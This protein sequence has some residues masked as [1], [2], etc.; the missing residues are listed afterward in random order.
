MGLEH[1]YK[2]V[3]LLFLAHLIEHRRAVERLIEERRAEFI[4]SK[5]AEIA[6]RRE[7]EEREAERRAVVEQ[8]RQRLLREHAT[9]LLGY[10]PKV[11]IGQGWGKI[12]FVQPKIQACSWFGRGSGV[13]QKPHPSK[14]TYLVAFYAHSWIHTTV[15]TQNCG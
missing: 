3:I 4:R 14:C 10:L 11:S 12:F 5:E 7:E 13:L 2:K 1:R 9:K 15:G 8:E 6:E